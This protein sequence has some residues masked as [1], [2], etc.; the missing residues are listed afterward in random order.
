M[1]CK[2]FFAVNCPIFQKKL[3]IDRKSLRKNWKSSRAYYF[4]Q[5]PK[6]ISKTHWFLKILKKICNRWLTLTFRS[7]LK[8][9]QRRKFYQ[10]EPKIKEPEVAGLKVC[11]PPVK[12]VYLQQ[13]KLMFLIFFF[14][15]M[16]L[17]LPFDGF[18]KKL[19]RKI[20]QNRQGNIC[21]GQSRK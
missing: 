5:T 6:L 4:Q 17:K 1:V 19:L 14:T 20:A 10:I 8:M 12:T 2:T 11:K 21:V 13:N 18:V 7:I 9:W 3:T 15:F 16:L